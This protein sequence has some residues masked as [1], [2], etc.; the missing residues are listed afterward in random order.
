M[1]R[2]Q[3]WTAVFVKTRDGVGASNSG[4][5]VRREARGWS[6]VDGGAHEVG[7]NREKKKNRTRTKTRLAHRVGRA[8]STHG[9]AVCGGGWR[10]V[11]RGEILLNAMLKSQCRGID[12]E[13]PLQVRGHCSFHGDGAVTLARPCRGQFCVAFLREW[14]CRQRGVVTEVRIGRTQQKRRAHS[15]REGKRGKATRRA[16]WHWGW[17][18]HGM[19]GTR[20]ESEPAR[21]TCALKGAGRDSPGHGKKILARGGSRLVKTRIKYKKASEGHSL[22]QVGLP[23]T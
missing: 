18:R 4:H 23:R 11:R 1:I 2:W 6:E 9:Q 8:Q 7:G 5:K 16:V 20:K 21:N 19:I 22:T 10:Q 15:H 3:V 12:V 13:L 17:G 14:G